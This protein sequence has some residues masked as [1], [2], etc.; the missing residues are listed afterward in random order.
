MNWALRLTLVIAVPLLVIIAR[1]TLT[2]VSPSVGEVDPAPEWLVKLAADVGS[3]NG[4]AALSSAEWGITDASA[5]AP[6]AGNSGGDP[7]QGE[8]VVVLRGTFS[9]TKS[10]APNGEKVSGDE[11]LFT[12]DAKSEVIQDFAIGD[13]SEFDTSALPELVDFTNDVVGAASR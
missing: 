3:Q 11:I 9:Y 6:S 8:Y 1:I 13:S 5:I 2:S 12:V 7:S 4:D 10:F